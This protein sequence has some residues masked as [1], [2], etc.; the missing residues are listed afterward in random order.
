M[1]YYSWGN[2]GENEMAVYIHVAKKL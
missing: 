2:R 1:P